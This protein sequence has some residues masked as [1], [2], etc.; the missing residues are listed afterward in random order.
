MATGFIHGDLNTNNILVKFADDKESLDGYYLIDFALFKENMPLLYDQRYLEMSYLMHAMS[1]VSFAKCVNFLTLLAVA[2]VPDPQKVP[3]EMSGVSAVIGAARSAFAAW[4]EANHPSLHDDLWGQYWLAGVAAG[5]S[6][7]HKA[8]QPDEQRLAGLIYAAANLKRYATIFKLPM[9]TNVELLYDENQI[10]EDLTK[11]IKSKANKNNLP[12]QPTPFIG[13]TKQLAAIKELLMRPETRLVTLMGP[14]GT[15]KT[16]LSLQVAQDLLDQFPNGVYFVPLADDT[17]ATQ[18]ISRVAQQLE[19]REGGR[20]LLEN[21]KDY[22][23]DKRMLLVLDN[24]EQ[25]VSAAPVVADLLA[26]TSQLKII[27]SSRIALNLHGERGFPVPPLE[28]PQTENGLTMESLSG[29]NPF[30]CSLDAHRQ[31]I[32]ALL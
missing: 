26:A 6:Y 8:G 24:F 13:R 16:R 23:R 11:H 21:V 18:F 7:T 32:P 1:Q 30:S 29:M 25:L 9:P 17:D 19:V 5:L 22:L 15:G 20:P 10:N 31:F 12:V 27:T 4:V 14:G 28:L 3:I 2:D